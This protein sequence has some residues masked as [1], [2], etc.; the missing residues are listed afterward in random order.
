MA[1]L[2]T[3]WLAARHSNISLCSTQLQIRLDRFMKRWLNFRKENRPSSRC[4]NASTARSTVPPTMAEISIILSFGKLHSLLGH[5]GA[6]LINPLG[7][8]DNTADNSATPS[9]LLGVGQAANV[10]DGLCCG[11]DSL[12][13]LVLNLH[14]KLILQLHHNLH[15]HSADHQGRGRRMQQVDAARRRDRQESKGSDE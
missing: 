8:S 14:R 5:F 4:V 6:L 2:S 12:C 1:Q 11:L 3:I 9:T 7:P 15:L 13:I 10:V